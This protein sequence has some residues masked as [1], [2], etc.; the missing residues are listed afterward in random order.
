MSSLKLLNLISGLHRAGQG[1]ARRS[2]LLS[3]LLGGGVGAAT[4]SSDSRMADF[5]KGTL[6]GGGAGLGAHIGMGRGGAAAI[7]HLSRAKSIPSD[8]KALA[9]LLAGLTGGGL[10]GGVLGGLGGSRLN[11]LLPE[12]SSSAESGY[13]NLEPELTVAEMFGLTAPQISAA[14][15]TALPALAYSKLTGLKELAGK[16]GAGKQAPKDVSTIAK[17][18]SKVYP[19]QSIP[20]VVTDALGP[21]YNPLKHEVMLTGKP[22]SLGVI[23]HEFGHASQPFKKLMS[24]L[25]PVR[26][27]GLGLG[28]L[29]AVATSDEPTARLAALLGT[30][31]ALPTLANEIGASYRGSKLLNQALKSKGKTPIGWLS[32][33]K[34]LKGSWAGLPTYLLG[35]SLPLQTYGFTK[36][37]GGYN[38][39]PTDKV[40][41]ILKS[42]QEK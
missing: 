2:A 15:G 3:A 41:T 5:L 19:S 9:T 24:M 37:F 18:F 32:K 13:V 35:A 28:S 21:A 26:N 6:I 16:V 42:L 4:G 7:S 38:N 29:G 12:K 1:G 34:A 39:R 17:A 22:T 20:K 33:L 23:A 36:A 10:G 40:L 31:A 25:G 27:L 14:A 8:R 11:D 30:G